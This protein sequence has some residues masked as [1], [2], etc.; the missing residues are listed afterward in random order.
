MDKVFDLYDNRNRVP[1]GGGDYVIVPCG[2]PPGQDPC[3][4]RDDPSARLGFRAP[5][6]GQPASGAV[7]CRIRL[8]EDD[9]FH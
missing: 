6:V 5:Y 9:R 2:S 1:F 8:R 7:R 3:R 4:A